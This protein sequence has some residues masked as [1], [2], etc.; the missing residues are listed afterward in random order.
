MNKFILIILLTIVPFVHSN[1]IFNNIDISYEELP[2][3]TILDD[4]TKN[5][6]ITF[7]NDTDINIVKTKITLIAIDRT[8][9]EIIEAIFDKFNAQITIYQKSQLI[10][11]TNK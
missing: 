10:L 6:S 1:N 2:I 7:K 4:L 5:S 11:I 3:K 8:L 9:L